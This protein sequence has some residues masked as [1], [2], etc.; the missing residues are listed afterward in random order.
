MP[1]RLTEQE[2]EPCESRHRA[3]PCPPRT[4]LLLCVLLLGQGTAG[5]AVHSE[6]PQKL[7]HPPRGGRTVG[8]T[9]FLIGAR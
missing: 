4:R 7:P 5:Q 8:L 1:Q 9:G 6:Q 2:A 3:A